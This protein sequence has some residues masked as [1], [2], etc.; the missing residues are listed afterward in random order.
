MTRTAIFTTPERLEVRLEFVQ[1][2]GEHH[3]ENG[4]V[5]LVFYSATQ[6]RTKQAKYG[7]TVYP[8][9]NPCN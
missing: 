7:L 8:E 3:A 4:K 6:Y 5:G 2:Y 1:D 9:P